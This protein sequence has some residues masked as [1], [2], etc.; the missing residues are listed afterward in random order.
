M[1]DSFVHLHVHTEYSMLD[2]AARI[3]PG[4]EL[5]KQMNQPALATT[6]HGYLF[7]SYE[8][9]K[10]AQDVGIKPIIGLE[11]Y[12]APGDRRIRKA[13]PI[14]GVTAPEN[15][16]HMT[17]WAENNEGLHNLFALST[18]ASF[19]GVYYKPR[20]DR[21]LLAQHSKGIIATT[22]CLS[23]EVNKLLVS[24]HYQEALNAAAEFQDIFGKDN[25]FFEIM[26]HGI[27]HERAIFENQIKIAKALN[28]PLVA[29][30]DAHYLH[31]GEAHMHDALLCVGTGAHVVDKKRMRF[32]GEGYYLKS[33]EEMRYLWRDYEEACD[34]TLAIA[35]RC[36]VSL[37]HREDLFP[38][39]PVPE[40]HTED[41]FFREEVTKGLYRRFGEITDKVAER[42]D[43]EISVIC[44]KGYAGYFLIVADFIRWAK[45]QGIRV[46]PGRGSAAG[47]LVA[48]AMGIT[49]LD[50]FEHNLLFERFMNPE[51]D[52]PPDIDIDI[53]D[54]RRDEVIAY[55]SEKYGDERVSQVVTY[56][57][58]KGK[59]A[60]KDASRVLS[61]PISLANELTRIYPKPN[62]GQDA[63]LDA[64]FESSHARY[65]ETEEL[66]QLYE[67]NGDAKE[68]LDLARGFEGLKRQWGVHA[69]AVVI[70]GV[71]LIEAIPLMKREKDQAIITQFDYPTCES[72]GL[73][74]M[75]F[76]GLRNLTVME[77]A[78]NN[79]ERNTGK[80]PILEDLPLD[81]QKTYELF[82]SGNTLGVFQVDGADMRK[83][84]KR[85]KPDTFN[86]ISAVL[87][88][89]RP[90]P[91]GANAH[92]SY[93]DRKNGREKISYMHPE[94][95]PKLK[96]IL[97]ETYGLIV[98]QEQVMK[99]AQELASY[100]AGEADLL[101]KAMGKKKKSVLDA[102]EPEFRD[103]MMA[104]GYS[105]ESFYALWNV[106][107][108][109]SDYAFNRAHTAAYGL[110]SYWTG[111]L[112]AHYP[113]EYMAAV[114]SS[115]GDKETTSLY[116][117]ECR[118]M[119]IDVLPPDVNKSEF[120]YSASETGEILFGLGAISGIGV[121]PVETIKKARE[122]KGEFTTLTDFF[123]RTGLGKRTIEALILSGALDQF[124]HTRLGMWHGFMPIMLKAKA[125]HEEEKLGVY[126]LFSVLG[127]DLDQAIDITDPDFSK[128][129]WELMERLNK[130]Y[131]SIG[132]Y[133]SGH[134]L[135]GYMLSIDQSSTH[136]WADL[137]TLKHDTHV[138]VGGLLTG[139]QHR[140]SKKGNPWAQMNL[141]GRD[142][143]LEMRCFDKKLLESRSRSL[144][145][146][147]QIV[148]IK[149]SVMNEDDSFSLKL[150]NI[151]PVT[152][153]DSEL[154]KIDP[155]ILSISPELM[156]KDTVETIT[157]LVKSNRGNYP[158]HLK[159]QGGV[160]EFVLP[161]TVS[162]NDSLKRKIIALLGRDSIIQGFGE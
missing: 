79:I 112:K 125:R 117:S 127:E 105:E 95:E 128:N 50:P 86:D 37:D 109:F 91:M 153:K 90:G 101:R 16:S 148:M 78:L 80:R 69:A 53:E 106:I 83:L 89:Y 58:M 62:Q 130:E 140:I 139:V 72:L 29:T 111:Y 145:E 5:A 8:F 19:D 35:E 118:R 75:D 147:G 74:K 152:V 6:D 45:E 110:V 63:P 9:I 88:L 28:M 126:D 92:Y 10:E 137:P 151:R 14:Q 146:D 71:P 133:L 97:A 100:S 104:N 38:K 4:L 68:V 55:V 82:S 25:Y 85:M 155:I 77:D 49:E 94:L 26:D 43:Y 67:T 36:E 150:N 162:P 149:A 87:A 64:V 129:E 76:L 158:L 81:D 96:P 12:I 121:G 59:S 123:F 70:S 32:D 51:R 124:G 120:S 73:L 161:G 99:I 132:I 60:I 11:G 114:L 66:R 102:I 21:E 57:T 54:R 141:L 30:N 108:P 159:P 42:R 122:E 22:G 119:G 143:I 23:G 20:A 40:G 61:K 156:T 84:L 142:G 113:S 39:F 27:E 3:R 31:E 157:S 52:S 138:I 46:G 41:S 134:P 56:G 154:E 2:G 98:F 116:L 48:Y 34:N 136:D 15:Y 44:S 18:K 24:G 135:D 115:V 107:V 47:A 93:A 7:N 131:N 144:M 13:L 103:R 17:M 1:S 33:S 160:R 65:K